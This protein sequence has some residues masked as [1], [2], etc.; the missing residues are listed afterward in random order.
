MALNS[1]DLQ[2]QLTRRRPG[3][4]ALTTPV[5]A[6]P[7]RASS[8][9][10]LIPGRRSVTRRTRSRCSPAPSRASPLAPRSDSWF[11][12]RTSVPT[13]TPRPTGTRVRVTPTGPTCSSTTSRRV[14][15]EDGAV[16]ARPLV[17]PPVN[18]FAGKQ[19]TGLAPRRPC[20]RWCDRGEVPQARV[21]R[22]DCR[23]RVVRW[24]DPHAYVQV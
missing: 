8:W 2:T 1:S 15:V 18:A 7:R 24:Q 19:L 22:R 23:V 13:T 17:G 20:R 9:R 14:V 16:L 10:M 11:G 3:Q 5:G 4:S 6:V 12:T 21:R